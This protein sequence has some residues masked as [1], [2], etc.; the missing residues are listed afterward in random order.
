MIE[1]DAWVRDEFI[2]IELDR[3][4]LAEFRRRQGDFEPA[5]DDRLARRDHG[6]ECRAFFTILFETF[7]F[8]FIRSPIPRRIP[9]LKPRPH[10]P[11]RRPGQ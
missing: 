9:G 10:I 11:P 8:H 4:R 6:L 3:V 2:L 5:L 7:I 1:A